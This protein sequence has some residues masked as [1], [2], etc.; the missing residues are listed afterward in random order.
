MINKTILSMGNTLNKHQIARLFAAYLGLNVLMWNKK[1]N[2]EAGS[3]TFTLTRVC[4]DGKCSGY[5]NEDDDYI[6]SKAEYDADRFLL[7]LR[8]IESITNDEIKT[9]AALL[10][11]GNDLIF[12]DR[13]KDDIVVVEIDGRGSLEES[14][15][16][17]INPS[18][19]ESDWFKCQKHY[20]AD[21]LPIAQKYLER[22][23]IATPVYIEPNHPDNGKTLLQLGL[24]VET[25]QIP[26]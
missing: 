21:T 24:A 16:L 20:F 8:S 9:V 15:I 19:E 10:F 17:M 13:K 26:A 12:V 11:P 4:C 14:I 5:Y 23:G 25:K 3:R 1:N 22:I 18:S 7:K 6:S 2:K